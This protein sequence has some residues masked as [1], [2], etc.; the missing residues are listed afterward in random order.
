[1]ENIMNRWYDAAGKRSSI[2]EYNGKDFSDEL[3]RSLKELIAELNHENENVRL[4]LMPSPEVFKAPFYMPPIVGTKY[5]AA[6][7]A[8]NDAEHAAG[9]IGEAFALECTAC[10]IGTCWIAGS[11]NNN[12]IKNQLHLRGNERLMGIIAFGYTNKPLRGNS[13]GKKSPAELAACSPAAFKDL[14]E[15]QQVAVKC[16]AAA[17]TAR[18]KQEFEFEFSNRSIKIYPTSGNMGLANL[19]CGI[20][21]LHIELGAAQCG[22]FGSWSINND[23]A[24]CFSLI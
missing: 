7:I 17:P 20:I 4:E 3:I 22:A 6:V 9:C 16:A 15:W 24:I 21:M 13:R 19:D 23:D 12:F 14:P 18:N 1:M 11:Y 5:S 8:L 10:N 2:R